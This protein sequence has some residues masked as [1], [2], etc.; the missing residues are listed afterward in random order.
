[1]AARSRFPG[2]TSD[3]CRQRAMTTCRETWRADAG[4]RVDYGQ[5]AKAVNR[6]RKMS[7]LALPNDDGDN[8][9]VAP[10]ANS[11]PKHRYLC[12]VAVFGKSGV[13]PLGIGDSKW[14]V[15]ADLLTHKVDETNGFVKKLS[16][17]WIARA[18]GTIMPTT[19]EFSVPMKLSC[20]E[21]FRFCWKEVR[22]KELFD[23]I[24]KHL[25]RFVQD[26]RKRF[27]HGKKNMGPD[28]RIKHPLLVASKEKL[29]QIWQVSLDVGV[30][31]LAFVIHFSHL[32]TV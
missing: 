9:V 29:G 7:E 16:G 3:A 20:F 10:I 21:E 5:K 27:L 2:D 30:F 8:L 15:S 12:P 19:N 22:N 25:L 32:G 28:A 1:M 17:E 4:L 18:G 23:K 11:E 13:G 24:E 6:E 26:H 14:G 31:N